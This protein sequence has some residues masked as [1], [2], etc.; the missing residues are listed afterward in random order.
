MLDRYWMVH[1][2][3]NRLIWL[4]GL[5]H[6]GRIAIAAGIL[7]CAHAF[8]ARDRAAAHLALAADETF[9]AGAF[10]ATVTGTADAGARSFGWGFGRRDFRRLLGGGR[11]IATDFV[12][13]DVPDHGV[14]LDLGGRGGE[15]LG[16][17]VCH[18]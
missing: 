14:A 17:V 6:R 11:T 4:R 3:S 7:G 10:D 1:D 16:E 5:A 2:S 12:R 9:I 18:P 8:A 15:V 13:V